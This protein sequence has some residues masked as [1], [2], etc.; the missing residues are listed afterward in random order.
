MTRQGIINC[1]YSTNFVAISTQHSCYTI[2][3]LPDNAYTLNSKCPLQ[4]TDFAALI[5]A[6]VE[7]KAVQVPG[8]CKILG[9]WYAVT[10]N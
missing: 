1:H 8:T 7:S 5:E 3:H 6:N 4:C 9:C 2:H 10:S